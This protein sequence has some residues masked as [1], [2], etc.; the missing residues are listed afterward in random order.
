MQ[1]QQFSAMQQQMF[2]QMM[3]QSGMSGMMPSNQAGAPQT[4]NNSKTPAMGNVMGN[5]GNPFGGGMMMMGNNPMMMGNN[6]MMMMGNNPMMMMGNQ[7]A[8]SGA[9]Q[10]AMGQMGNNPMMMMPVPV[11]MNMPAMPQMSQQQPAMGQMQGQMQSNNGF[12]NPMAAMP[13]GMPRSRSAQNLVSIAIKPGRRDHTDN[14]SMQQLLQEKEDRRKDKMQRNREAAKESRRRKQ[15]YVEHLE[16]KHKQ[17]NKEKEWL[18]KHRWGKAIPATEEGAEDMR[19]NLKGAIFRR[20]AMMTSANDVSVFVEVGRQKAVARMSVELTNLQVADL[21]RQQ[22]M[23]AAVLQ[24][25]LLDSGCLLA[26]AAFPKNATAG[27]SRTSPP[28]VPPNGQQP[29]RQQLLLDLVSKLELR[30]D[31]RAA[32]QDMKKRALL[33]ARR[34]LLMAKAKR[35]L[36]KYMTIATASGKALHDTA[37]AQLTPAQAE[38]LLRHVVLASAPPPQSRERALSMSL[39]AQQAVAQPPPQ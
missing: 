33:E 17:L 36:A 15:G 20:H 23:S 27:P 16:T 22:S 38:K 7:G 30:D 18:R 39:P 8:A 14:N 11:F 26:I 37:E 2:Q 6:P 10:Q 24:D 28:N 29:T 31:Q 5:M 9:G 1:G 35:L 13:W 34:M 25:A 12:A 4:N 21:T 32:L 3:M 19:R